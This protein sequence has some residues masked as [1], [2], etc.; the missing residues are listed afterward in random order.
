[1][2]QAVIVCDTG[3]R[4]VSYTVSVSSILKAGLHIKRPGL[5][6]KCDTIHI[7]LW[8]VSGSPEDNSHSTKENMLENEKHAV[9]TLPDKILVLF[10]FYLINR[11]SASL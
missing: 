2:Y 7:C 4:I 5:G 3:E 11:K 9:V 1:M 8:E 10:C 6:Q